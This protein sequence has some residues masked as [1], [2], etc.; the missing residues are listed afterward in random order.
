MTKKPLFMEST[1]IP[2]EKTAGEIA[3]VL[4]TA[5]ATQIAT[6]YD[7]GK[8]R[9]LRWTMRISGRE[10][11][12][13]MPVRVE[14]IYQILYKR[15]EGR[16]GIDTGK[17]REKA[18][19]VAWRQLLRWVQAQMAMIDCGMSEASEV[20]LPYMQTPSGQ[21]L[22]EALKGGGFKQLAGPEQPQ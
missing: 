21:T 5:G 20:F 13:S 16:W 2:P 11:L 14:P 8:V 22:F 10:I 4:V 1:E 17:I 18:E 12:F 15:V 6:E 7:G 3:Q 9:G 19:R